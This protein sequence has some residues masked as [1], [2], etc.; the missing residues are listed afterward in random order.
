MRTTFRALAFGLALGLAP[1]LAFAQAVQPAPAAP[2]APPP[3]AA[4]PA[5]KAAAPVAA[6]APAPV[7][8]PAAAPAAKVDL[9][10]INA[11]SVTELETL[12]GVGKVRAEAIVKGRPYKGKD[13]LVQKKII[14]ENVYADIKDKIIAKQK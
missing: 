8:A 4:S 11:A 14:P 6:P 12:H 13:E 1:G 2:K 7:A 9:V 3:A 5:S 10:D